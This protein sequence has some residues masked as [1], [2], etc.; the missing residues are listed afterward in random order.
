M[1]GWVVA[2]DDELETVRDLTGNFT[3]RCVAEQD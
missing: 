2:L 3:R 1:V